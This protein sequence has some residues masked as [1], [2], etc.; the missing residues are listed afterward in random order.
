MGFSRLISQLVSAVL[1]T[2]IAEG[3]AV[4]GGSVSPHISTIFLVSL[5]RAI[6]WEQQLLCLLRI[7]SQPDFTV[8]TAK[9]IPWEQDPV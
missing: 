1:T 7:M 4:A 2:K 5:A 3:G 6:P 8:L 9:N